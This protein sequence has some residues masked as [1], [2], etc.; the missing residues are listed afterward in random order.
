MLIKPCLLIRWAVLLAF[1]VKIERDAQDYA[2]NVGK[3]TIL[4]PR[5]RSP[6]SVVLQA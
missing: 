2:D 5:E 4:S 6:P 1:D 3:C